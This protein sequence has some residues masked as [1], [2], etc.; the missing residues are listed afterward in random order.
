M[1]S[2]KDDSVSDFEEVVNH[3]PSFLTEE[4]ARLNDLLENRVD[5][6][7]NTNKAKR[8]YRSLLGGAK[9]KM[10]ELESLL[11]DVRAQI[12]SLQSVPIVTNEPECTDCSTFLGEFI[13]LKEKY[14]SKVELAWCLH[15]LSC[16]A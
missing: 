16:F 11:D 12:G 8:E 5:V 1:K 2:N 9:E 6:L 10:V 7:R 13:V 3:D 14:S 4:N 15:L